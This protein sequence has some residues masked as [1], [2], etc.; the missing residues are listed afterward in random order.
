MIKKFFRQIGSTVVVCLLAYSAWGCDLCG[1]AN[2]GSYF[3]IMPQVGRQFVGVRYRVSS[4]DSHLKSP[5]LRTQEHFQNVELWGRFYPLKRVQVLAFVPYFFNRQTEV[6]SNRRF[7]LQGI[8][9]MTVL[10]N[11]NLFNTFWDSTYTSHINHSLLVGGGA[12]LPT[13]RFQY[14]LADPTDVA[15]PNFQLGTGSVDF[16][17][18]V[19]YSMRVHNWGWN[20]DLTYKYNTTNADLYRF[21]NRL[22]MSSLLFYTKQIGKATLM[23]NAGAYIEVAAKDINRGKTN[24]RTGGYVSMANAGLEIYLKKVSVGATYQLPLFQSLSN[25]EIKAHARGTVHLT[26]MF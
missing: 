6:L 25:N 21:G 2:G 9:D 23:P 13:G 7:D 19:L 16:L 8:G 22:T 18:S 5:M 12:K 3:G 4:F 14:D 1:C 20:T 17:M 11:Y 15:N 24:D 26:L 10:A